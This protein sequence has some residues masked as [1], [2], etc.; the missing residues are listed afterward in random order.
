MNKEDLS[1]LLKKFLYE[2]DIY[3]C[4]LAALHHDID[5]EPGCFT[6]TNKDELF[7]EII[8]Y[9]IENKKR[10]PD[11]FCIFFN[12]TKE[13]QRREKIG[14]PI[15]NWFYYNN[16]WNEFLKLYKDKDISIFD[17]IGE[18]NEGCK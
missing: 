9:A 15:I 5:S 2:N 18:E 6:S 12:W 17:L 10:I 14:L 4:Y 11:L 16:K 7:I 13:N 1:I 8:D 3:D